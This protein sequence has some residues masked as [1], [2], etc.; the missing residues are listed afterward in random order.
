MLPVA[1]RDVWMSVIKSLGKGVTISCQ[2][3]GG[4]PGIQSA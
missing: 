1:G 2:G 4:L 3:E